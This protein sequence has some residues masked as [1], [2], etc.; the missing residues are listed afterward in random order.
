MFIDLIKYINIKRIRRSH[1][2]HTRFR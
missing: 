2:F 1:A